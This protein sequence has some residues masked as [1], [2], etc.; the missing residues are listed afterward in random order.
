MGLEQQGSTGSTLKSAPGLAEVLENQ[1]TDA[2]NANVL[3]LY[4][5]NT[6]LSGGAPAPIT[7]FLGPLE[8]TTASV[9]FNANLSREKYGNAAVNDNILLDADRRSLLLDNNMVESDKALS[10]IS[11]LKFDNGLTAVQ[12]MSDSD[13]TSR[14]QP[15][16]DL[17]TEYPESLFNNAAAL[18]TAKETFVFDAIDASADATEA[19]TSYQ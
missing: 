2:Q 3:N 8:I 19:F 6:P 9:V 11:A 18:N 10:F 4:L 14:D 7:Q 16:L 5:D 13:V 1:G 15:D 12:N 17:L